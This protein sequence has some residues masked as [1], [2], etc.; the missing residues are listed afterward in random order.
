MQIRTC[1]S[2]LMSLLN[3]HGTRLNDESLRTL[4]V[5]VESIVNSRPLTVNT[6]SDE[7]IE[8]LTPNHLLTMKSKVVLPPPGIFQRADVYCRRRWRAVQYLANQF[9][10]RWRKEYVHNLQ[11]RQKWTSTHPN[12]EV[13]DV[14]LVID[15]DSPR[16]H[17]PMGR[18]VS[19]PQSG[20]GLVRKAEVMVASNDKPLSRP[21]S[22]LILLVRNNSKS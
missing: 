6:L 10:S 13:G 1:R 16:N 20:D 8:P 2:V 12:V 3:E 14:V 17:W 4:L 11:E 21:I 19:A 9:W 22:K 15:T 5:E 7:T 18:I